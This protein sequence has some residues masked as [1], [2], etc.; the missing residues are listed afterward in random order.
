[1]DFLN[2]ASITPERLWCLLMPNF[3]GGWRDYWGGS[4]YWEGVLFI[5]VTAFLLAL[6]ALGASRHPQKKIVAGIALF[7]GSLA[8]GTHLP[9]FEFFCRYFPLFGNFR[10]VGKLNVLITLCL[11][12][13]A[14]MGMD[15]VF[16]VPTSLKGFRRLA[17]W[18]SGFFF[19]A[20]GLFFTVPRLGGGRV[21]RQYL[22]YVGS[23]VLHLLL[24]GVLLAGLALLAWACQKRPGLRWMFPAVAFLELFIFA[25]GNLPLFDFREA[26]AKASQIQEIYA[27]DP[28]D[29]RVSAPTPDTTL[30]ARGWDI[31]GENPVNSARY[32]RFACAT[33]GLDVDKDALLIPFFHQWPP[34]L[35]LLRL[36]YVLKRDGDQWKVEKTG[37]QEPPRFFLTDRFE[38]LKQ[39]EIFQRIM[40]PGFDPTKEALLES[41]PG[42]QPETGAADNRVSL[43]DLSSDKIEVEAETSKPALLVVT[44]N[45]SRGWKIEP[46]S[47]D[48]QNQYQ[49]MPV[50]GFQRAI[51]LSAGHHHFFMEYRPEFFNFGKWISIVSWI[52]FFALFVL[53]RR[54]L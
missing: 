24:C 7:L 45:Y 10:G 44:D 1:M 42:I 52:C 3:F 41:E 46:I 26:V 31:W 28:G 9:L 47:A 18:G 5:S 6:F 17:G 43:N 36:R 2:I 11:L 14:A 37:F 23:M 54:G 8:I 49:V 53:K 50:N 22:P 51:P 21:F 13:L 20:A 15:E 38:V 35:G 48:T 39:D 29:Y 30:R 12:A 4:F 27:R 34:A 25:R 16:N 33:Q 40:D 32:A 19:F